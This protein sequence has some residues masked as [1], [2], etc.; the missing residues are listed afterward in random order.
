VISGKLRLYLSIVDGT[1]PQQRAVRDAIATIKNKKDN[2]LFVGFSETFQDEV[3]DDLLPIYHDKFF[4]RLLDT[5]KET[6]QLIFSSSTKAVV[7]N[8]ILDHNQKLR[9][10]LIIQLLNAGIDVF[11]PA[12]LKHFESCSKDLKDMFNIQNNTCVIP[13]IFFKYIARVVIINNFNDLKK[14][15]IAL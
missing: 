6:L 7:F 11:V 12:S 1:E 2:I 3:L 5:K 10:K 9:L 8:N 13:T 4:S 15:Q 14:R